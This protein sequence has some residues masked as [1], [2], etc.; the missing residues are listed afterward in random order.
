MDKNTKVFLHLG[1]LY[2]Y[3]LIRGVDINQESSHSQRNKKGD[4]CI[5][6]KEEFHTSLCEQRTLFVRSLQRSE[7][8]QPLI[9]FRGFLYEDNES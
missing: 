5:D 6:S 7:Q 8:P 2:R 4:M 9:S 1:S 3:F